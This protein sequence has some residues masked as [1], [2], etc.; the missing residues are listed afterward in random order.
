MDFNWRKPGPSRDQID[1]CALEHTLEASQ[2]ITDSIV[3]H[4]EEGTAVQIELLRSAQTSLTEA[5][6]LL[7]K[8]SCSP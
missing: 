4:R 8:I 1:L 7:E 2:F 5:I 6:S 3:A